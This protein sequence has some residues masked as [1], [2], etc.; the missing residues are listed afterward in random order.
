MNFRW[1]M[2]ATTEP[3]PN[4]QAKNPYQSLDDSI[5]KS[6]GDQKLLEVE[7]CFFCRIVC[8]RNVINVVADAIL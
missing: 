3:V 6:T 2:S 8:G 4:I 1:F 7:R 5:L